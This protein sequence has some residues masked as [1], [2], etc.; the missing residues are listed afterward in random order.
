MRLQIEILMTALILLIGAA[1]G[2]YIEH[3]KF[4]AYISK[5]TVVAQKQEVKTEVVTTQQGEVSKDII[6]TYEAKIAAIK[7]YYV[8]RL[9]NQ[10][11]ASQVSCVPT[12]SCGVN[13]GTTNTQPDTSLNQL[14]EQCAETTQ[15]LESLQDWVSKQQVLDK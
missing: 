4:D 7:R 11:S 14:K 1:G 15:Q 3:L 9:R 8:D 13:E 6:K 12:T 5:A 2:W 10:A